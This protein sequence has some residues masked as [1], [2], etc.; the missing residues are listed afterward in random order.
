[1]PKWKDGAAEF[2]V[3]VNRV[4]KDVKITL[5]KPID[6]LL[7]KPDRVTFRIVEDGGVTVS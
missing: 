3:R 4:G 7:K 2:T 6:Q 1:M 5:P